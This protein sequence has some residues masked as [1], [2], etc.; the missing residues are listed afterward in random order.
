MP[1]LTDGAGA[2]IAYDQSVWVADGVLH[3]LEFCRQPADLG[4]VPPFTLAY[5]R[6]IGNTAADELNTRGNFRALA[7]ARCTTLGN[8]SMSIFT[9]EDN[10]AIG[11]G[12]CTAIFSGAGNTAVGSGAGAAITGGLGNTLVGFAAGAAI[13]E[14][15]FQLFPPQLPGNTVV[16]AR[17]RD[18]HGRVRQH[19][20]RRRRRREQRIL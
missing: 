16:G 3:V 7:A 13:T 17:G 8:T 20:H 12:A 5:K 1:R 14:Q 19:L 4:Y 11:A 18:D 15:P 2:A 10:T 6:Y 9:G